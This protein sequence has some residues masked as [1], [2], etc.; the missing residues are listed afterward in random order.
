MAKPSYK[1]VFCG[2][3]HFS[4]GREFT[5]PHLE[6]EGGSLCNVV[7]CDVQNLVDE[8]K[9]CTVLIPMM[10]K[11][12][13]DLIDISTNLRMIMQFGV[14]IEGIDIQAASR[15]GIFVCNIPSE[16]VGNAESCAELCIFLAMSLLRDFN[17]LRKSISNGKLGT[18]TGRTLFGS[19]AIIYGFGG[20]GKNLLRR[21]APFQLANVSVVVRE[22]KVS[23][24]SKQ[25]H[26]VRFISHAELKTYAGTADIVFLCCSLNKDTV[27]IVDAEFISHLKRGCLIVNVSRVTTVRCMFM[28]PINYHSY[29]IGCNCITLCV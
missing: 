17:A 22:E 6:A 3:E 26:S 9:D 10:A 7:A 13:K 8:I 21:L 20:M 24:S 29:E 27:G 23:E 2:I 11:V 28:L 16:G 25:N 12:T 5:K 15:R 1:I 4:D 18:P 19:N 14:G